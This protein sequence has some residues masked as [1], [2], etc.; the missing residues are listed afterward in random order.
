[1]VEAVEL[2]EVGL[3]AATLGHDAAGLIA[4]LAEDEGVSRPRRAEAVE[5][6]EGTPV[7]TAIGSGAREYPN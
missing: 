3:V 2:A 5:T 1:M 6:A 4:E 7:A